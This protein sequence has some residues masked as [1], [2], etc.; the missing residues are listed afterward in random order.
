VAAP[1]EISRAPLAVESVQAAPSVAAARPSRVDLQAVGGPALRGP[2]ET[3]APA[4]PSVGPRAV[5]T[6]GSS[7]GTGAVDLGD[8]SSVREGALSTRDVLG[9][10]EGPALASV[11]TRVGEGNLRGTGGNGEGVG[12]GGGAADCDSRPEVANYMADV[13]ERTL[14]RWVPPPDAPSRSRATLRFR[15]DVGGSASRVELVSAANPQIGTSVVQAMR[16][17]SPFPPLPERARC[18]ADRSITGVFSLVPENRT[19]AN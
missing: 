2:I 7:V 13:K 8:S 3:D 10:K 5:A 18:L 19:V 12:G 9:A 17:A 16:S 15:L 14:A 4:G 1:R 6:G 11:N